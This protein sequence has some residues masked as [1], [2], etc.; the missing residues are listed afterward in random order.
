MSKVCSNYF[1]HIASSSNQT[2]WHMNAASY[3]LVNYLEI[4][5]SDLNRSTM[6]DSPRAA[7]MQ[8]YVARPSSVSDN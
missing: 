3:H 7:R 2:A 4:M 8:H 6:S 5:M 1:F